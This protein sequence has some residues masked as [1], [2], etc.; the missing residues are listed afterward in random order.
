MRHAAHDDG[1]DA[2]DAGHPVDGDRHRG[3]K[4]REPDDDIVIRRARAAD[5]AR[6]WDFVNDSRSLD[7][8]SPYAYLM[9]GHYFSDTCLVAESEES[10]LGFVLGFQPPAEPDRVFVW[11]VGVAREARGHGLGKRLLCELVRRRV[12][13]DVRYLEASITP[14]N[15]ASQALFR[16]FAEETN[17]PCEVTTLFPRHLFPSRHPSEHLY[18]IGPFPPE[19]VP[20]Q[21]GASP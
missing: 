7:L 9:M 8:N 12:D 19:A 5:G 11:Q 1:R 10:L 16:S 21:A 4:G 14:D 18:T 13:D 20:S 6:L 3:S 2:G 15:R 17:A